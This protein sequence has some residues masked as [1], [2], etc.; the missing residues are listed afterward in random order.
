MNT[1]NLLRTLNKTYL[2]LHES[3]RFLGKITKKIEQRFMWMNSP[4]KNS[5]HIILHSRATLERPEIKEG[6]NW[7]EILESSEKK[8]EDN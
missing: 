6:R 1:S 2:F 4:E 7:K 8:S 5:C 3:R